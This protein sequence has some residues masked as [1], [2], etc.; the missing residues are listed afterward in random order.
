[1]LA[2]YLTWY[3]TVEC[4]DETTKKRDARAHCMF[5]QVEG[6]YIDRNVSFAELKGTLEYFSKSMFVT[7]SLAILTASSKCSLV[8]SGTGSKF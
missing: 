5:H 2:N 3:L 4:V 1:M 8:I 6:L 7:A